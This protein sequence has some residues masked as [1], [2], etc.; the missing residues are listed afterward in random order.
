MLVAIKNLHQIKSMTKIPRAASKKK[1]KNINL[2][3]ERKFLLKKI[4]KEVI[5]KYKKGL[6]VLDIIQY[7][8]FINGVWQRYRVVKSN[9]K[10][11]KFI[12]TIKK[13][14]SH[15]IFEEDERTIREKEFLEK[16]KE[17]KKNYAVIR[18]KRY[19][20]KYKGLK[21]EVDVY[22]DLSLVILEVELPKLNHSFEFPDGLFEEII[23]E[24]TGMKQFSNFNLALKIKK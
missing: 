13:S 5:E 11:T 10:K 7:Y 1:S 9:S 2:E 8:F 16:K 17:H 22:L 23:I 20:I 6:Q 18:K 14:I 21:F 4:P 3:I 15:G 19:A 12:H 24:A